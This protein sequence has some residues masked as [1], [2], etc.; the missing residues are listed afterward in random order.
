M[1]SSYND[2]HRTSLY[3]NSWLNNRQLKKHS[4]FSLAVDMG[5]FSGNVEPQ[6]L[7]P[8]SHLK[9]DSDRTHFQTKRV[10]YSPV[11]DTLLLSYLRGLKVW[12]YMKNQPLS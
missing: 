12:D 9:F 10:K 4:P 7:N 6:S 5:L 1:L 11:G 2:H 8:F 3:L